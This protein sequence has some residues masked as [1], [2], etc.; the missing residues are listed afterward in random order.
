MNILP[1]LSYLNILLLPL[2]LVKPILLTLH[3]NV[4]VTL[5]NTTLIFYSTKMVDKAQILY[6]SP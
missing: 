3:R 4:R 1:L 5:Q 6:L 2:L